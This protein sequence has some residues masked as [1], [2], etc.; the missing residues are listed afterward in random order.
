M[1]VDDLGRLGGR[2][3][4]RLGPRELA[5]EPGS[6]AWRAGLFCIPWGR[7]PWLPVVPVALAEW[8]IVV[9]IGVWTFT[10]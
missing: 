8:D 3:C 4:R 7:L 2:S 9:R 6:R 10:F 5:A 1:L